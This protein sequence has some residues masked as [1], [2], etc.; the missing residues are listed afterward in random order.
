M[1]RYKI[2]KQATST[3][4][5]ASGL[6]AILVVAGAFTWFRPYL[7]QQR[8][9]VG[10]VAAPTALS[11]VAEFMVPA[12]GRACM[13]S[14]TFSPRTQLATFQLH[15]ATPNTAGGPPVELTLTAVN[16][17]ATATLPGGR[18]GGVA[19]LAIVPPKQSEIGTVCFVNRGAAVALLNGTTEPRTISRSALQ[20]DGHAVTGDIALTFLESRPRSLLDDVSTIFAHASNLTDRLVPVWV[21]WILAILVAFGLPLSVV[22]AFYLALRE[23]ERVDHR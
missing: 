17:R 3:A 19:I 23:D 6:I 1:P 20:I 16:Y 22:S 10:S 13:N 14:V 11:E 4:A 2:P 15:P 21:V 9:T 8:Q 5:L 7:T 12:H 18:R